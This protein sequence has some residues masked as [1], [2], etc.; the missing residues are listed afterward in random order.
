MFE[1]SSFMKRIQLS[2]RSSTYSY[3]KTN[4]LVLLYQLLVDVKKDITKYCPLFLSIIFSMKENYK[5]MKELRI[6][7]GK[8]LMKLY[9]EEELYEFFYTYYYEQDI[10]KLKKLLGIPEIY[11]CNKCN[12]QLKENEFSIKVGI[13]HFNITKP[14][15][16]LGKSSVLLS[17]TKISERKEAYNYHSTNKRSCNISTKKENNSIIKQNNF[18]DG[19]NKKTCKPYTTPSSGS[20]ITENI[21][22]AKSESIF[23]QSISED[24]IEKSINLQV[25]I[26]EYKDITPSPISYLEYFSDDNSYH[27]Y[28]D[29]DSTR[30]L[31]EEDT[32]KFKDNSSVMSEESSVE[33]ENEFQLLLGDEDNQEK[34]NYNNNVLYL[35]DLVKDFPVVNSPILL[36][37][38]FTDTNPYNSDNSSYLSDSVIEI[39]TS[40]ENKQLSV[41]LS[42]SLVKC[43]EESDDFFN[44]NDSDISQEDLSEEITTNN[45]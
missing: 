6:I 13:H 4:Y 10:E 23:Q 31:D 43:N 39:E 42:N 33:S 22:L 35:N 32:D 41:N 30:S 17:T 14:V 7:I 5:P 25:L 15:I 21:P 37:E 11:K 27:T 2:L 12:N 38:Y 19:I 34:D 26:K 18:I 44:I 20:S 29:T 3:T 1:P 8:Y 36:Q 45:R 9:N 24:E 28:C 40:D 16:P